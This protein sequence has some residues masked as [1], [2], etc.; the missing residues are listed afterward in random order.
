MEAVRK[1]G[2]F[3]WQE[4]KVRLKRFDF[5][6]KMRWMYYGLR[7]FYWIGPTIE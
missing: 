3:G 2:K 5:D 6:I 1:S 7:I 4:I